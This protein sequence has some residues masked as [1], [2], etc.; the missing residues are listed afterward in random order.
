[1]ADG[2][3]VPLFAQ[4]SW[5][6]SDQQDMRDIQYHLQKTMRK[7]VPH[8]TRSVIDS[9]HKGDSAY[10]SR[11]FPP[12]ELPRWIDRSINRALDAYQLPRTQLPET[13]DVPH[14][15]GKRLAGRGVSPCALLRY[16]HVGGQVMC[17]A[18]LQWASGEGLRSEQSAMLIGWLWEVV[19]AHSAAA[20]TALCS[21]LAQATDHHSAGYLLDAL[22]NGD[23][24][25]T[26]VA[27][28]ARAFGLVEQGRY[29]VIVHESVP[30]GA[31]VRAQDLVPYAGG[32]RLNWR[33]HGERAHAVVALGDKAPTMLGDSMT[34]LGE[35]RTGISAALTGLASLGRARQQAESAA[36]TLGGTGLAF[37]EERL[38]AV[39][40]NA[41][42]GLAQDLQRH[43][44]AP[45]LTLETG[46]RE[47]LLSTL[48]AW[49][50]A[51]GSVAK[52]ATDM[53]CH[54]N[55]VLN[56]L[57]RIEELTGRS[58]SVPRDV[59]DLVLALESRQAATPE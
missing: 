6:D 21:A 39:M 22:L 33:V 42:P 45:V 19:D 55:T 52:V 20:I 29:A 41:S 2:A 58:L 7:H 49:L 27:A 10:G 23:V 36:R 37:F 50:A 46:R 31:P 54:R 1:M 5:H 16:Y 40:L 38:P 26:T 43:V 4:S 18:A 15:T 44:L 30:G 8:L 9:L 51:D 28:V 14:R 35:Y 56:R 34:G 59:V 11:A 25:E 12:D 48:E 13:L 3:V 57:R 24:R 32:M 17:T 53:D 47:A